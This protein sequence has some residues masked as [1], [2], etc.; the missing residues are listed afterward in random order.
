MTI[1]CE[2]HKNKGRKA[3]H[4]KTVFSLMRFVKISA[5]THPFT[6]Q[7]SDYSHCTWN[8]S[9]FTVWQLDKHPITK[10]LWI[11]KKCFNTIFSSDIPHNPKPLW[12]D[13][14][15]C[16]I[17]ELWWFV[18]RYHTMNNREQQYACL[19]YDISWQTIC[20]YLT[21]GNQSIWTLNVNQ[22]CASSATKIFHDWNT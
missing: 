19:S 8:Y 11:N 13:V 7:Y 14:P 21:R 18:L 15:Q 17:V 9:V 1:W 4:T 10:E 6:S 3:G 12:A 5:C 20:I 16:C 22:P 2:F